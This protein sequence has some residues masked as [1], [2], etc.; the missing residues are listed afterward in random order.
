[1]VPR[2][3]NGDESLPGAGPLPTFGAGGVAPA[4]SVAATVGGATVADGGATVAVAGG[5]VLVAVA[6]AAVVGVEVADTVGVDV[7]AACVGAIVGTA[8]GACCPGPVVAVPPG[9]VSI[10]V[11]TGGRVGDGAWAWDGVA[12]SSP[13]PRAAATATATSG[14][15]GVFNLV[16]SFLCAEPPRKGARSLGRTMWRPRGEGQER[17]AAVGQCVRQL[18]DSA[19]GE[20]SSDSGLA[21]LEARDPRPGRWRRPS[22]MTAA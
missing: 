17:W 12:P 3:R 1:M 9:P 22:S 6:V 16:L 10:R 5:A 8:V 20:G 2:P 19:A 14:L 15:V 18:S 13:T 4:T 7:A 11:L 21:V